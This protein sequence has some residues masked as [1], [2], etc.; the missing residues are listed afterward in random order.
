MPLVCGKCRSTSAEVQILYAK[1]NLCPSC[2]LDFYK[3]R[4]RKTVEEFKMFK[5]DDT[6]GVAVSGGKDS[7][8]LLHVL[9]QAYPRL[10]LKALH[11]NLG[12]PEYSAHCQEKVER[13]ANMLDVELHIFSLPMALGIGIGDFKK[14]PL[15]GKVCSA[16]GTIKRRIFEELAVKAQVRVLATG[17]NL[18]DVA[19]VM[20]NN[21]LYGRWEQFVRL[22][23]VLPPL[24]ECMASKVKPLIKCPEY[25]NLLYC[26]Y[27]DVPFRQIDCPYATGTGVRKR[28]KILELLSR[29]NPY[30]KHQ[31]LNR[32][33]EIMPLIEGV[34]PKLT[35]GRCKVCGFPSSREICAFC[36][37]LTM[38]KEAIGK[39]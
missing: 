33:L 19:G 38:V 23:P 35:L 14:T 4:V 17:H 3:T 31:L 12:I 5:E 21:F 37:R 22:K 11:I 15:R 16:C 36:R 39:A 8:A 18:E 29:D 13:L 30:F 25:E 1:L 7:A 20:F 27:G 9:R 28:A 2:F 6:V 10:K 32:F 34:T 24:S 26:V